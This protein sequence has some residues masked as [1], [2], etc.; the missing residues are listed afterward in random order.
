MEQNSPE[1]A[2]EA[3]DM[4]T[5]LVTDV[6][7]AVESIVV[8]K[9]TPLVMQGD[10]VEPGTIVVSG[11]LPLENDSGEISGYEYCSSDADVWIRTTLDYKDVF[12]KRKNV[13]QKSGKKRYGISLVLGRHQM[14]LFDTVKK[15][16]LCTGEY[17]D[18]RIGRDFYLPFQLIVRTQEDC[19]WQEIPYTREEIRRIA[20]QR[21]EGYCK[22]LEKNAIQ[23]QEK[24]VIIKASVTEISVEGTLEALV[25][26]SRRTETEK[27]KKQEGTGTYGIDTTNVGHSD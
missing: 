9:G 26:A 25:K 19:K 11:S 8:R 27:I 13:L 7:G 21:L 14:H 24:S 22:N 12:S 23:I 18:P 20:Q 17:Y 2:D 6:G 10:L 1:S 15:N 16:T 4:A 3:G 5:D